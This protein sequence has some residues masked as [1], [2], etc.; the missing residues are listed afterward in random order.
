MHTVPGELLDFLCVLPYL[1]EESI[2]ILHDTF[3]H[4]LHNKVFIATQLL[5]SCVVADKFDF[6]DNFN[7]AGASNISAFT[8]N[9]DTK[10]YIR[11]IFE[12]LLLPWSY[13]LSKDTLEQYD[14]FIFSNY[15]P[16]LYNIFRKACLIYNSNI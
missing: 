15:S 3:L 12:A 13:Q 7:K 8:I 2:V 9:R 14:N 16:D 11:N 6:K 4:C 1:N 10:K 5:F